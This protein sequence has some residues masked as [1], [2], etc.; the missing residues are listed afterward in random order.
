MFNKE[1]QCLIK[2]VN[3]FLFKTVF[4]IGQVDLS[5]HS[6]ECSGFTP[7]TS[8]KIDF[9]KS[10]AIKISIFLT[11]IIVNIASSTNLWLHYILSLLSCKPKMISSLYA[12]L[13]SAGVISHS[14][15][16]E[17]QLEK[18]QLNESKPEDR[19]IREKNI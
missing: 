7:K 16:Y 17:R 10:P 3:P 19:L 5:T 2:P 13:Y 12:I 4:K 14:Q 9:D 6:S 8:E 18:I 15:R 11:S 1:V